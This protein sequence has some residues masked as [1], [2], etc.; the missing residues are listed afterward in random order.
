M[1]QHRIALRDCASEFV[2]N[3]RSVKSVRVSH[4]RF[5]WITCALGCDVQQASACFSDMRHASHD[6]ALV[7]MRDLI[8]C[9]RDADLHQAVVGRTC[10]CLALHAVKNSALGV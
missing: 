6:A 10:K 4:L 8:S 1:L 2:L 5:T 7:L 9:H 3:R